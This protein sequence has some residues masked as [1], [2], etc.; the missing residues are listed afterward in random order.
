MKDVDEINTNPKP[1]F[2]ACILESF[3]KIAIEHGYALAIHGSCASDMDLIAVKW[4]E[5]CSKP[6]ELVAKLL[7]ELS[8]YVFGDEHFDTITNVSRRYKNQLHYTIPIIGTWY[9]DL[10]IIEDI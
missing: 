3:R 8:E 1:M 4:R 10:T 6:N 9:I 5:D 2:Y 7:N